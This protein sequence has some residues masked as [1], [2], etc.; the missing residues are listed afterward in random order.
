VNIG[1]REWSCDRIAQLSRPRQLELARGAA[2]QVLQ[3]KIVLG[4][5]L[6][7]M[8]RSR[9]YE[10]LGC[11]SLRQYA[12]NELGLSKREVREVLL[13]A[14][15]LE[16]L[17]L[18]TQAVESNSISWSKLQVL[19]P[20]INPQNEATWLDRAN[21]LSV[22]ELEKLVGLEAFEEGQG[23]WK[24]FQAWMSSPVLCML[25]RAFTQVRQEVGRFVSDAECLE[26][27]AAGKLAGAA[28]VDEKILGSLR[29]QARRD[30]AAEIEAASPSSED[31]IPSAWRNTRLRF[32]ALSQPITG[33]QRKEILRRDRYCCSVSGCQNR[34]WLNVHHIIFRSE[35]GVTVE[36][37][38]IT[39]CT[40]CHANL[41]RG[42]LQVRGEPPRGLT[43]S[44]ASGRPLGT[45]PPGAVLGEYSEEAA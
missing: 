36:G 31:P 5:C 13:A 3:S 1:Q 30:A 12:V 23:P 45:G 29:D 14:G 41:H 10:A 44:D 39:V 24:N 22:H 7:V 9:A 43:W 35:G 15:R 11:S 25:Q 17:P 21:Q 27:L 4:R 20:R 8:Q 42:W 6:L 2:G 32:K 18:L 19:L 37:N 38:L 34:Q 40:A 26:Y 16:D 28:L 33:P